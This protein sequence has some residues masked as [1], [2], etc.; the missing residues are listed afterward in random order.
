MKYS[1]PKKTKN[2]NQSDA[3]RSKISEEKIRSRGKTDNHKNIRSRKNH[4]L[5]AKKKRGTP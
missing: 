4:S 5:S 3:R 2:Q 1:K